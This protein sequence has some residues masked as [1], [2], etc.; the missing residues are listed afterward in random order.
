MGT[1][2]SSVLSTSSVTLTT[3]V[4][5]AR[6]LCLRGAGRAVDG[7]GAAVLSEVGV[8]GDDCEEDEGEGKAE[9]EGEEEGKFMAVS[10]QEPRRPALVR[11]QAGRRCLKKLRFGGDAA[12]RP[13]QGRPAMS[14]Q[15]RRQ[16]ATSS[17]CATGPMTMRP[18]K[19]RQIYAG[20][21]FLACLIVSRLQLNDNDSQKHL[22]KPC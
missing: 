10:V 2:L 19:W 15:R 5:H 9:E 22:A 21:R 8:E 18:Q 1:T 20:R 17:H 13:G 6:R 14:A 3:P 12:R 11:G 7:A 4:S 16:F